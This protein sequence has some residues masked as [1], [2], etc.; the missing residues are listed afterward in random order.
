M[1]NTKKIPIGEQ[2]KA[3]ARNSRSNDEIVIEL[4][5]FEELRTN[6]LATEIS[7]VFRFFDGIHDDRVRP[8]GHDNKEENQ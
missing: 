6:I 2:D 7:L 8:A 1:K 3:K 5:D 4:D